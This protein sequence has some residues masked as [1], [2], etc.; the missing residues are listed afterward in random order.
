MIYIL[1][2]EIVYGILYFK[3]ISKR[4]KKSVQIWNKDLAD[5]VQKRNILLFV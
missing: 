4:K 2:K 1:L 3:T 5:L